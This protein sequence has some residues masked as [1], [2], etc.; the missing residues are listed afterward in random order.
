[1]FNLIKTGYFDDKA[2]IFVII[3]IKFHP[4]WSYNYTFGR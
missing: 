2:D 4:E 1:M 3:N